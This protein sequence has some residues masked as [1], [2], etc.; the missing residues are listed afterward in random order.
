VVRI[1]DHKCRRIGKSGLGLLERHAVLRT[2]GPGL[3]RIPYEAKFG[4]HRDYTY[5]VRTR[6]SRSQRER[7]LAGQGGSRNRSDTARRSGTGAVERDLQAAR[8]QDLL[9]A[10]EPLAESGQR[11]K[12]QPRGFGR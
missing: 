5:G 11:L 12:A 1:L 7:D 9:E 10:G 8:A 2:V 6:R 3:A 4:H